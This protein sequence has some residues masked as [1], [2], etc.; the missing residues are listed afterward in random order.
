MGYGYSFSIAASSGLK[1]ST[2]IK[3]MFWRGVAVSGVARRHANR[4]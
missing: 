3:R 2:H 4:Y 1:S